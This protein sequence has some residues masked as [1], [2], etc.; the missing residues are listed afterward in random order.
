MI[1]QTPLDAD[2]AAV[3]EDPVLEHDM[4]PMPGPGVPTS[5]TFSWNRR[6]AMS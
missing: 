1:V 3:V 5:T 4:S 2:L 6:K